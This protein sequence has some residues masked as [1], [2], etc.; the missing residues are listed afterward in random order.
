M[1]K[2]TVQGGATVSGLPNCLS[3]DPL[4]IMRMR[5]SAF[6]RLEAAKHL[7]F[8]I[9]YVPYMLSDIYTVFIPFP[10][11]FLVRDGSIRPPPPACRAC[12]VQIGI[13]GPPVFRGSKRSG[14]GTVFPWGC[15]PNFRGTLLAHSTLMV[16]LIR[17]HSVSKWRST[18]YF[19]N[20]T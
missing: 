4:I 17:D 16:S 9:L 1:R 18:C 20:S 6:K 15:E 14:H 12:L 3:L 5:S 8:W 10:S 2:L 11:A 7:G 19:S 13:S